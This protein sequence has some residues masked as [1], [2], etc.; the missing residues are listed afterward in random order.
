[1]ALQREDINVYATTTD[2]VNHAV[3]IGNATTPF[4]L[5]VAFQRFWLAQSRE[6][7]L[8]YVLQLIW[9]GEQRKALS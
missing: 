6:R 8:F 3:L 2:R 7:M 4:A 9:F 1:M 5:K